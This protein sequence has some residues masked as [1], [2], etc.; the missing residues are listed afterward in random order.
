MIRTARAPATPQLPPG[1]AETEQQ[2]VRADAY[3]NTLV[4][5][6]LPARCALLGAGRPRRYARA[7][8]DREWVH[9]SGT[10]AFEGG[11]FFG[12]VFQQ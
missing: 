5:H 12:A 11:A 4:E 1:V 10:T 6:A 7:V 2:G 8:V 9:A 3:M